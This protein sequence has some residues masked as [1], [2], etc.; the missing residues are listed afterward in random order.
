VTVSTPSLVRPF[1]DALPAAVRAKVEAIPDLDR[2]LWSIVAEGRAAWPDIPLDAVDVVGFIARQV[3]DEL[4]EAALDGLRPADLYLA[5]GCAK[6]LP[7]AI[8]SFDR[9]YMREVDIALARMR[10]GPPR[11][12]DVKQLVRQRLFVGGGTSGVPTSVGKIAE[13]GGRGDL[14]RWVRSVAVRTCLNDLRKGKR[15][16][17]VDDDQLIAQHAIAADD[18]EVEYMKRTYANEFKQAFASA[19]EQLGAREQT[20]LRYHHVDGLNIDEIGAIYRVHRVTAFRWLEKAK[21]LL[22]KSTLEILRGRLKL[23]ADELDS[24]LRMIRSQIHLSIVRQLG[25]PTDN[26]AEDAIELDASELE[27]VENT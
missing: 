6:G 16:V 23:P 5:C 8:N 3:T 15:E 9:D 7:I 26:V 17:L 13:Y 2:R 22:V 18:P 14:R 21:E 4:A 27:E 11:L 1:V 20:L 10:I 24:V 12:S 19:L 25:G